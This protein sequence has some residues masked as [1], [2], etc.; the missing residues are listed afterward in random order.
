MKEL[1]PT[2]LE[3]SKLVE[4]TFDFWFKGKD[5]IRSP[6]PEYI[7]A[8]LKKKSIRRFFEWTAR[9]NV[10]A[11]KEINDAVIGEKFEEI[12]FETAL[13]LV[14]TEDEKITINYPFLPRIGDEISNNIENRE[15]NSLVVGRFIVKEGDLLF[16]KVKLEKQLSQ[17]LWETR[18]ELPA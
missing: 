13:G 11:S 17:E 16:L 7:R 18:F 9:L 15:E 14:L 8:E 6:F 4:Q 10:K 1:D 2:T 12:I 5:H 3:S